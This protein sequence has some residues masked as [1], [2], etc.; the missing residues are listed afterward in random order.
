METAAPCTADLVLVLEIV[1]GIGLLVGARLARKG[2]FRQHAWCQSTIVVLNL[3]VVAVM[4]IPSFRVHVLPRVPAKLGKAYYALA[5]THAAF[6]T[7]TEIAG[8]YILLSAG[9]SVLPE[10]LRITKYKLWMRS[11]LVLW[12]VVLLLGVATYTRWYVPHLFRK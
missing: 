10:K 1:M 6:G 8:L 2:R 9:T 7:M 4:M 5:T 11:V 12:W 3:A